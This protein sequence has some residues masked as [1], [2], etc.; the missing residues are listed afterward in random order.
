MVVPNK[1]VLFVDDK[2]M[3]TME[4]TLDAAEV[5][6]PA[7]HCV[8]YTPPL[9]SC[10]PDDDDDDQPRTRTTPAYPICSTPRTTTSTCSGI[11]KGPLAQ[12]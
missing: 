2:E 9:L 5:G 6:S 4:F 7:R 8:P 1:A 10:P 3:D 11:P 12:G